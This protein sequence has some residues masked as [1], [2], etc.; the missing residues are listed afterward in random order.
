M[1]R[2]SDV[3]EEFAAHA[4]VQL[5]PQMDAWMKRFESGPSLVEPGSPMLADD[6]ALDY[7]QLSHAAWS[8]LSNAVDNLHAF[9]SV[10][11]SG[12]GDTFD[13]T[14]RPY[15]AYA[16]LRATIEN[17]ATAL[18]MMG[19]ANRNERVTRRLRLWIQ[20]GRYM[21]NVGITLGRKAQTVDGRMAKMT[22]IVAARGLDTAVIKTAIGYGAIVSRAAEYMDG[23]VTHE[24]AMWQ[25]LS[26]LTHGQ[27]W[28]TLAVPDHETLSIQ[29]SDRTL[30]NRVT[31]SMA[32]YA[33]FCASACLWVRAAFDLYDRRRRS[34]F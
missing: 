13:V 26:G 22:H 12:S 2:S 10:A 15:G 5:V 27:M 30:N 33:G 4:L 25:V 9:R 3:S 19:P 16:P 20:D 14:T 31:S 17:A 11:I 32:T 29:I 1:M 24:K 34:P 18:Y 28:A 8:S 21:D 6:R 7:L 23:Q